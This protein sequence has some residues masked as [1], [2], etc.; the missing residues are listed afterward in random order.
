MFVS[1]LFPH[2]PVLNKWGP[3]QPPSFTHKVFLK[4]YHADQ[5][6]QK[7]LVYPPAAIKL[8]KSLPPFL[9]L[10]VCLSVSVYLSIFT[11]L[12]LLTFCVLLLFSCVSGVLLV[13]R[14][15]IA[16]SRYRKLVLEAKRQVC[17]LIIYVIITRLDYT[18]FLIALLFIMIF[19]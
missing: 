1:F 9:V 5:L 19:L 18:I 4:Y 8:Q 2:P 14:G 17:I 10:S 6:A 3:L 12:H 16:R 7:L 13:A 15:F 11:S